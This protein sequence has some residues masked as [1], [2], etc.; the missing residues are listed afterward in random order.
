MN[1]TK[2]GQRANLFLLELVLDLLIFILCAAVC[3][4]LLGHARTMSMESQNLTVAVYAAQTAAEEW[5]LDPSY[6]LDDWDEEQGIR[7]KYLDAA[8]NPVA[9]EEEDKR[10]GA[11]YALILE[12]L[13]EASG[14]ETA[15]I[16][17]QS[18]F[19]QGDEVYALDVAR[20]AEVMGS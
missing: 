13:G 5:R 8:G 14:V 16:S 11:V 2:K 15:H 6:G 12:E 9:L 19:P 3:L 4:T 1:F 18:L 17:V 10:K 7:A 20:P